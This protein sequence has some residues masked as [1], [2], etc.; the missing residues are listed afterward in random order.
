MPNIS[1]ENGNF[2]NVQIDGNKELP[3]VILSNS[4]FNL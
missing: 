3:K 2:L 1:I 4:F